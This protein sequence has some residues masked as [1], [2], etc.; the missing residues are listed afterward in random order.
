MHKSCEIWS[1][2]GDCN[3]KR[4]SCSNATKWAASGE[5]WAAAANTRALSRR[6]E[7]TRKSSRSTHSG[8][9]SPLP[10][11]HLACLRHEARVWRHLVLTLN[12]RTSKTN[13]KGELLS[14]K[15]P[16]SYVSLSTSTVIKLFS[17]QV[18]NSTENCNESNIQQ[19]VMK[20]WPA[21]GIIVKTI[22]SAGRV[23]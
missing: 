17:A 11:P 7:R 13:N 3:M 1:F 14:C 15:Q 12:P 5:T 20:C 21:A 6:S 22:K 19:F 9:C 23:I 2:L 18:I 8:R 4:G 16:P 10:P